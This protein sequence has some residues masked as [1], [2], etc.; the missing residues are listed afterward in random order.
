MDTLSQLGGW[1]ANNESVF[2]GIA[3]LIVVFGFLFTALNFLR[4]SLT[5]K[6]SDAPAQQK[7]ITFEDL[8]S[9]SPLSDSVCLG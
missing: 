4:R 3:A 1:I 6:E 2:S 9:P 8:S 7:T 5:G